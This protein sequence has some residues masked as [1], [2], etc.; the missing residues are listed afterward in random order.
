MVFPDISKGV[1]PFTGPEAPAG[2]KQK[3]YWHELTGIIHS[4]QGPRKPSSRIPTA[5]IIQ[6][7]TCW[8]D[9][10]FLTHV[11][12]YFKSYTG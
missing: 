1:F 12:P 4:Q 5:L 11:Q 9:T 2:L 6:Y 8:M 7:H 10:G 3:G